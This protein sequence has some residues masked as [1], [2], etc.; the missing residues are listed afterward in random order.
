[1]RIAATT[2]IPVDVF[3]DSMSS[4]VLEYDEMGCMASLRS[5]VKVICS[6]TTRWVSLLNPDVRADCQWCRCMD[7]LYTLTSYTACVGGRL[8]VT[9]HCS[10]A[11]SFRILSCT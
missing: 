10:S 9:V 8:E 4:D 2:V 6:G 1:M 7:Y 5:F 11:L 3:A